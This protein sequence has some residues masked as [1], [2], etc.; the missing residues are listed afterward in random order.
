MPHQPQRAA[1]LIVASAF[2]FALT[3]ATVKAASARLPHTEVVFFRSALGLA[4]LLPW[5]VRGGLRGL[6]TA[7]PGLHLFRGL[8]GLAAMYCFFYALAHLE[9]ATAVLLNYSAPVFIP[10]IAWLWLR[11]PVPA[12]LRWAI[13]LGFVGIALILKPGLPA[14]AGGGL[15]PATLIGVAAGVLAAVSFVT[16]R[17]LHASEPTTRIVFYFGV[18]STLVSALPL[19]WTWHTPE[20]AL[21]GLLAAMGACA[22]G[23]QLLLTRAYALAPAAQ[24]GPFT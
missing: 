12:S 2:M 24:V 22:T 17:R 9:L 3:G 23:G 15:Q 19:V 21:W 13:P 11:E 18:I 20:P 5:L 6:A 7:T 1:A 14:H 4:A 8:S 10:F 16:I